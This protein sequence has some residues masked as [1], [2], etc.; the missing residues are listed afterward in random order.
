VIFLTIVLS[1]AMVSTIRYARLPRVGLRTAR[2][3]IGLG[4]I[5]T[6]LVFG[7]WERDIFFFP[8]GLAYVMYGFVR[9][10]AVRLSEHGEGLDADDETETPPAPSVASSLREPEPPTRGIRQP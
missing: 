8:L 1:I 4:I 5:L 6:I 10:A 7:I 2:G 3:L 9:A